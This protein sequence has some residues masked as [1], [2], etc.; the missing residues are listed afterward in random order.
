MN[1]T[2]KIRF[3]TFVQVALFIVCLAAAPL[4]GAQEPVRFIGTITAIEGSTI[5]VK[6]DADGEH[7]F[8]VPATAQIRRVSPGQKNLSA[9]QTIPVGSLATGDRVLVKLAP[10]TLKTTPRALEVIAIKEADIELEHQKQREDWQRHGVG[11]L[12]KSV[13]TASGTILLSSGF[14]PT[15][16]TVTVH[17]TTAT[18]LKR[19][20][21]ASVQYKAALPAPLS[22]IHPGDQL[23]ARGP[24]NTDGSEIQAEEVVSGSFRNISGVI[25]SLDASTS[26][27]ELKDL[28]TKKPVAV[29]VMPETQMRRVPETVARVLAARL[30]GASAGTAEHAAPAAANGAEM[31]ANGFRQWGGQGA[32]AGGDPQ[33]MLNGLSAIP[34]GDIKKGEA[35]MLVATDGKTGVTAITLLVGVE[36]LLESPA[37]SQNLLTNWSLGSGSEDAAAQ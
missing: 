10:E 13:D 16:R 29:H 11:G 18:V 30:K 36:P 15:A 35:V 12:V 24:K 1:R 3:L 6:T 23:R 22:A 9:A 8:E 20:A 4:L 27:M 32:G 25:T 31:R 37:A 5:T 17:V 28:L 21:P 7:R 19:Y 33:Q 14:G 2:M 26:T 34:F